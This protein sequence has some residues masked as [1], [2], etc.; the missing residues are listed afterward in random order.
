MTSSEIFSLG[1]CLRIRRGTRE[2]F[3]QIELDTIMGNLYRGIRRVGAGGK[4]CQTG[5][6]FSVYLF[7]ITAV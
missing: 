4:G 3:A 7:Y 5:T 1:F 6:G 2:E